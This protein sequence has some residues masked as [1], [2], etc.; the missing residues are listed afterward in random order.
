VVE[1]GEVDAPNV[2]KI[3][4]EGHEYEVLLGI[5]TLLRDRRLRAVLVEIHFA[6]L[7]DTGRS[8]QPRLIETTL[9]E[10]GFEIDWIDLSHLLATRGALERKIP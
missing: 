8:D 7:E 9:L 6:L 3:D 10:A 5:P 4:V 2:I 1:S